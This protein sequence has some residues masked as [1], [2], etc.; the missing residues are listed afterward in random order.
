MLDGKYSKNADKI[1]AALEEI[2][3]SELSYSNEGDEYWSS[4]CSEHQEHPE[5]YTITDDYTVSAVRIINNKYL[6]VD[7]GGYWYAGGAHGMPLRAQHMFD[8]ETGE[9]KTIVDFY[10]L[11][12]DDFKAL[13]AYKTKEDFLSYTDG[14]SPYFAADADTVF[15]QAYEYADLDGGTVDF[16]EDGI[17]YYYPPYE[18]GPYAAGYIDVFI[19]YEELLGRKDL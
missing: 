10:T 11:S 1:N 4:D 7:M 19:S 8:L 12:N 9:E 17:Y 18:M 2:L 5:W 6:A 3:N 15:D 14:E 13:V 16:A